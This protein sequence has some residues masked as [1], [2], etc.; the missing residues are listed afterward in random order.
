MMSGGFIRPPNS[1]E[2]TP[3][4]RNNVVR[5]HSHKNI[6]KCDYLCQSSLYQPDFRGR[7]SPNITTNPY[8]S[9]QPPPMNFSA[10]QS[11]K[12]KTK[13]KSNLNSKNINQTYSSIY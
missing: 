3:D 13:T 12:H 8:F 7:P 5:H 9:N 4:I 6:G 2:F 1:A 11:S 10:K